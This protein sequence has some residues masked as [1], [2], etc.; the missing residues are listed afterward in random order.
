MGVIDADSTADQKSEAKS[1]GGFGG[2]LLLT[3]G[4]DNGAQIW[5]VAS[6]GQA[7]ELL[8][9]KNGPIKVKIYRILL[10][11]ELGSL[12]SILPY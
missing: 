3:L 4:Y 10:G 8:S 5:S 7:E 6:S 11:E 12:R 9:L 1:D 2:S